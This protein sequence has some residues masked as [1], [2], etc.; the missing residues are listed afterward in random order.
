MENNQRQYFCPSCDAFKETFVARREETYPVKGE[1]TTIEATV[2]FCL[3]C[4]SDIYDAELDSENLRLA[5]EAFC[6]KHNLIT[7]DEVR[8]IRESY[9]LS[10]R[11]LGALLGWG[12][13]TI[14]RYETGNVPDAGHS[15]TLQSLRDPF[16]MASVFE[17]F[18][19]RLSPSARRKV[20]QRID[21]LIRTEAPLKVS[22]LLA[23]ANLSQ[24]PN[25]FNGYITFNPEVFGEMILFFAVK[26]EGVL[27][28]KL[29][30]LLWYA[31]FLHFK[32]H[33][34]SIS[35]ATYVH[36]P[37][38]PVPDHYEIWLSALCEAGRA[39]R[40][41]KEFGSFGDDQIFVGELIVANETPQFDHLTD[42]AKVV[43]NTVHER[44]ARKG[45]TNISKISH[46]ED[47]WKETGDQEPI[48]Y[49]YA[50]TLKAVSL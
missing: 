34:V 40:M 22:S 36:L 37:Y 3:T 5:Y 46:E 30:K 23:R 7:H 45:S 41:E 4:Q 14:H 44:F 26:G 31:D 8:S 27:K 1:N 10:Q 20:D 29:N 15:L 48:S 6:Q 50:E 12:E 28:T 49:E 2:R 38:G 13:I 39:S 43:L 25:R 17:R 21:E 24:K 42:S 18:G 19:S 32:N 9:G 47:G 33:S 16:Y 11:G 35:G